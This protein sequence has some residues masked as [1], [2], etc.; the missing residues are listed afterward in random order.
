MPLGFRSARA[1]VRNL[2][3]RLLKARQVLAAQEL[4][5]SHELAVAF[6]NL[7]ANYAN[8]KANYERIKAARERLRIVEEQYRRGLRIGQQPITADIVLRAQSALAQAESAFYSS[9]VNYDLSITEIELRKGS[10]LDFHNVFL[11][12]GEWTPQAY[13]QALRRARA[14][15]NALGNERLLHSEPQPFA[16]P[17]PTDATPGRIG[18]DPAGSAAPGGGTL[19]IPPQPDDQQKKKE[20]APPPPAEKAAIRQVG[21][22]AARAKTKDD[23]AVPLFGELDDYQPN[24]LAPRSVP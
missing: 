9:R 10:L 13:E 21:L 22:K 1:Q 20:T 24:A 18:I 5:I 15:S 6:Q 23:V 16:Y 12:E 17:H 8:M 19:T 7:A 2:E 11:A 4:E 3:L 14:R